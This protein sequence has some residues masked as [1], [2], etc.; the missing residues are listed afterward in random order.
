MPMQLARIV[1]PALILNAVTIIICILNNE[2]IW[3]NFFCKHSSTF[4]I[5]TTFEN[6]IAIS[7]EQVMILDFKF[8]SL[9]NK[10]K[11]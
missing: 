10:S 3:N 5:F 8:P 1:Q 6:Q 4:Q 7:F 11:I 2:I 9:R